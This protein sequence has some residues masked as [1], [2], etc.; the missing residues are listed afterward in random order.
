MYC[1]IPYT[2][3]HILYSIYEP[4]TDFDNSE[5]AN[6]DPSFPVERP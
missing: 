4:G 1:I 2:I 3:F 5:K 6:P